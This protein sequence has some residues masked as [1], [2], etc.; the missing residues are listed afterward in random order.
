M[1]FTIIDVTESDNGVR[2]IPKNYR[3]VTGEVETLRC[4]PVGFESTIERD[5]VHLLDFNT[6]VGTILSQPLRIK[7]QEEGQRARTYT[8]DYLVRFLPEGNSPPWRTTVYEVKYREELSDRWGELAPGFAAARRFCRARG[9][10]FRV[11]TERYIRNTYH[12]NVQFLRDY[13]MYPDDGVISQMLLSNM[14]KLRVAT[15]G[16]LLAVT[17]ADMT[18]RMEAV[19]VLW[20]LITCRAIG[21]NLMVSLNMSS[22][23][24]HEDSVP[25]GNAR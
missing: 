10:N 15:P 20:R 21:A 5:F 4:G 18:N 22:E 19:G 7:Y 9:W 8:P 14:K 6:R 3:S 11:V 2:E 1:S 16:Q 25:Y 23:I 17:F 12:D 24:W 13:R